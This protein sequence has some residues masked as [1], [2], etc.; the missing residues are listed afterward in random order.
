M[1]GK[2][3]SPVQVLVAKL[4]VGQINRANAVVS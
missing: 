2:K 1:Q 3:Y 4:Q